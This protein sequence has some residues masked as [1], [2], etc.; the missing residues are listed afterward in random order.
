MAIVVTSE[1]KLHSRQKTALSSKRESGTILV[2]KRD[3]CWIGWMHLRALF[4]HGEVLFYS[5]NDKVHFGSLEITQKKA[6]SS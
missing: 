4:H 2:I 1:M 5:W 3:G 6:K